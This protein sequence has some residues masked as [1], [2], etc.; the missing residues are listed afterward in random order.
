M[1]GPSAI[2]RLGTSAIPYDQRVADYGTSQHGNTHFAAYAGGGSSKQLPTHQC[3]T[4][5][6]EKNEPYQIHPEDHGV[7]A[8][9]D[10]P[11]AASAK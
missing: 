10:Q 5:N 6:P 11:I 2:I 4:D 8:A 9:Y 7:R 3:R 1:L